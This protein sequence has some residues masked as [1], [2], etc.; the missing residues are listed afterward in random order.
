M[1]PA[2]A[3]RAACELVA[4]RPAVVIVAIDGAGGAGKS[5]LARGIAAA[6][7]K[8]AVVRADDFYRP[9]HGDARAVADPEYAYGNCF[10]WQ[11]LRDAALVPLRAGGVARYQRRDWTS[12]RLAE[13]V[14]LAPAK[15]VV[16]DGVYS[17]RPELRP[18]LDPAIF[19]DAPRDLRRQ[20]MLAR[21][22]QATDWFDPWMAA[23]DWYIER[24]RPA[25]HADLIVAGA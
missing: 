3:V 2:D 19:V 11:R 20:R 4:A 18:H 7:R 25:A 17:S 12:G 10:E 23:E 9:L 1:D 22:P 6:L 24:M 14:T 16:I 13:W 15:V 5:T 21:S 8:A